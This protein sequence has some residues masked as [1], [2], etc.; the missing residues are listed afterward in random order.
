MVT[1][2]EIARRLGIHLGTVSKILNRIPMHRAS[3]RTVRK[4]FELARELGYDF[5]KQKHFHRRE[6]PR[7]NIEMSAMLRYR[8]GDTLVTFEGIARNISSGGVLID[9]FTKEPEFI[10]V[11]SKLELFLA[12]S[13]IGGRWVA[14][15]IVRFHRNGGGV[16][17]C[18]C[19]VYSSD[20]EREDIELY[21]TTS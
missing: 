2:T 1:K 11:Q 14:C 19:P 18:V 7:R 3:E 21:A 13:P 5:S 12:G 8:I 4:V 15:R 6:F 20:S 9:S 10:P 16:G 17:L